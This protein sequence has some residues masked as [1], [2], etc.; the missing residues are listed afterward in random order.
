MLLGRRQRDVL[1]KPNLDD[2]RK[3]AESVNV[4]LFG[5]DSDTGEDIALKSSNDLDAVARLDTGD[6]ILPLGERALFQS[7]VSLQ[8]SILKAVQPQAHGDKVGDGWECLTRS[9]SIM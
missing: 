9:Y 8:S 2:T 7:S 1:V 5:L 3:G 4:E 6:V